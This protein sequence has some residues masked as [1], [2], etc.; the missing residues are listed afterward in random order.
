MRASLFL[1]TS[2]ALLFIGRALAED[3]QSPLENE[4]PPAVE[5]VVADQPVVETK[6]NEVGGRTVIVQRVVPGARP[7]APLP[8]DPS[9]PALQAYLEESRLR[10]AGFENFALSA[11][12]YDN[13]HTLVRWWPGGNPEQEASAWLNVNLHQLGGTEA[14]SHEGRNFRFSFG[15]GDV[16]TAK[17]AARALQTGIAYAPPVIP[18]FASDTPSAVAVTGTSPTAATMA[19]VEAILDVFRSEGPQ[20]KAAYEEKLRVEAERQ[21]LLLANPQAPEDV[22]IRYWRRGGKPLPTPANH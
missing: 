14:F 13:A 19:P 22:V 7:E 1:R 18:E 17:Q 11:T 2:A 15:I 10:Y 9:D 5:S 3:G 12:V 20:L 8:V 21:A 16:D 4:H 6:V